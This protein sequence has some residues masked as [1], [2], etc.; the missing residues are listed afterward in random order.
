M[1]EPNIS[2]YQELGCGKFLPVCSEF[3]VQ[4]VVELLWARPLV[5]SIAGKMLYNKFSPATDVLYNIYNLL[6]ACPLVVSVAGVRVV[7]FGTYEQESQAVADKPA[8]R[9]RKIRT[10]YVR[11]VGL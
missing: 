10:V 7:E 9:L 3:V 8:R 1:L 6:W 5:V 4:Q 2:T 11:A